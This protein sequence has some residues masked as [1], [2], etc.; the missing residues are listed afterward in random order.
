MGKD[1]CISSFA[2]V[3]A[4]FF[5][6]YTNS[7]FALNSGS[8]TSLEASIGSRDWPP[9]HPQVVVLRNAPLTTRNTQSA[10][11]EPPVVGKNDRRRQIEKNC[12][13]WHVF[14]R[15]IAVVSSHTFTTNP[16]CCTTQFTTFCTPKMA[17]SL[18]KRH[19]LVPEKT[20]R[21]TARGPGPSRWRRPAAARTPDRPQSPSPR[22]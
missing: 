1:P 4:C 8:E 19:F 22:L 3:A 14:Q 13:S 21:C 6:L 18:Q 10:S 9:Y 12:K 16:P 7:R 20:T 5:V 2:F 15:L 11:A 17:K